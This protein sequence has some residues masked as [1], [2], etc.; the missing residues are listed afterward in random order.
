MDLDMLL[1]GAFFL[2]SASFA[3]RLNGLDFS[4]VVFMYLAILRYVVY[5]VTYLDGIRFAMI[6]PLKHLRAS[7]CLRLFAL[8]PSFTQARRARSRLQKASAALENAFETTNE[9]AAWHN[10]TSYPDTVQ[11]RC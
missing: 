1:A 2:V 7:P 8:Y 11:M 3:M 5:Y 4:L 6:V 10:K 9:G